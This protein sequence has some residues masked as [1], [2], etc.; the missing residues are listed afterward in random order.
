MYVLRRIR[1]VLCS[2]TYN[3]GKLCPFKT[4]DNCNCIVYTCEKCGRNKLV[5]LR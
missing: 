3:D 5:E 1:S 2:H 4:F